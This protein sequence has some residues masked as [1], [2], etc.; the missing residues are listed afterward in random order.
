MI[1]TAGQ[2]HES[3]FVEALLDGVRARRRRRPD[4]VACDKGYDVPRVRRA[5]RARRIKAVIPEKRKPHGRRPGTATGVRPGGLPPPQRG[6]A[7][8]GLAQA[9][10]SR[11]DE[12]R[13]ARRQLL[14]LRAAGNDQ[15]VPASAVLRQNLA[16]PAQ[17]ITTRCSGPAPAVEAW[18]ASRRAF[19]G[20]ATERRCVSGPKMPPL[21]TITYRGGVV[22]FR[23]PDDWQE[24]NEPAGGG[25]FY[26]SGEQ[27]GTLRL[28]VTTARLPNDSPLY[29]VDTRR[30]L[31]DFAHEHGVEVQTLRSGVAMIRFDLSSVD[32]DQPIVIRSW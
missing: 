20:P 4:A 5:L 19:A 27:T 7:V 10:P 1:L 23:I 6:R 2:A 25:M 16:R 22:S 17:G 32:Q 31:N 18:Q 28:N 12:V 30:V 26:A 9:V 13:Q 29:P 14:G 8:R 21:K 3:G 11:G 24:E 15:E